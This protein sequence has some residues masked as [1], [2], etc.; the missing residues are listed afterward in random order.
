MYSIKDLDFYADKIVF[1]V[2]IGNNSALKVI[3]IASLL[4]VLPKK[5]L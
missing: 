1:K 3:P 4:Y 2:E 5:S